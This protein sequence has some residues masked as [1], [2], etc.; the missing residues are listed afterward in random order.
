MAG[1]PT[2]AESAAGPVPRPSCSSSIPAEDPEPDPPDEDERPRRRRRGG[3]WSRFQCPYCGSTD[4][5][6]V[7]ER[8][9]PAGWAVFAVL[10]LFTNVFCWIGL[11]I[12]EEYRECYGCGMK[13]GS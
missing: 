2:E 9:S 8:A 10:L 6:L 3:R 1:T 4:V 11:L 5:P 12:K 13:I 7:R